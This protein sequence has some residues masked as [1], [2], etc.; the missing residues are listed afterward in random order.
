[1]EKN[2]LLESKEIIKKFLQQKNIEVEVENIEYVKFFNEKGTY[3][4]STYQG[5]RRTFTFSLFKITNS[6]RYVLLED[7][8]FMW[9]GGRIPRFVV[10][11]GN[12]NISFN[13]YRYG[14]VDKG[15]YFDINYTLIDLDYER[16]D[17]IN[18]VKNYLIEN[19]YIKLYPTK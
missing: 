10:L 15:N 4:H 16:L 1:M 14:P 8:D 12:N 2:L 17:L 19:N 11:F 13:T 3:Y 6:T 18:E 9:G 5:P 7:E